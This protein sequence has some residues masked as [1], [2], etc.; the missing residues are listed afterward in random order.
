MTRS[1][2]SGT[3]VGRRIVENSRSRQ[4]DAD[5]DEAVERILSRRTKAASHVRRKKKKKSGSITFA[6]AFFKIIIVA[7]IVIGGIAIIIWLR[8]FAAANGIVWIGDQ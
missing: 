3:V 8:D 5:A 4:Q 2:V 1:N 7:G 6:A